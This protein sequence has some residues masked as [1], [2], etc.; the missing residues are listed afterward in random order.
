MEAGEENY[1]LHYHEK[2]KHH[3][4]QYAAGPEALDWDDQPE[5]F[6]WFEGTVK[7]DLPLIADTRHA[8]YTDL[9]ETIHA[10]PHTF[11]L[12]NIACLLELS[13]GLSA[14]KQYGKTKWAL[15][16]NPSSGNLHAEEAYIISN[17][18][19]ELGSGIYH[20]LSRD[21]Q[22]EQRCAFSKNTLPTDSI[23]IGLSSIQW[24]E[25]WKY[26]E[27]AYRYC[28]LDTGH[29]IAALRYAAAILGWQVNILDQTSDQQLATLLGIDRID[30]YGNAEDEHPDVLLTISMNTNPVDIDI[31]E[32]LAAASAGKWYG[33]ANV[34]SQH[35]THQWPIIENIS[36]AAKKPITEPQQK[37]RY[38]FNT[39]LK[40]PCR[41]E[42][43]SL[44][45][46]R[47]SAQTFDGQT[48]I[49]S[50]VF[51]RILDM[52]LPR[53]N[54]APWDCTPWCD[55][56]NLVL[57]VHRV[58]GLQPGLYALVRNPITFASFQADI[59]RE[60][61]EWQNIDGCPPHLPLYN[62]ISSNAQI[63]ATAISCHQDIAGQSCF[64]LAMI[65]DFAKIEKAPWHYRLLY[66][67]AGMI[68]Q[69]LY[70]EAEAAGLQGT[71]IGC[72]FDD[73][74]HE[75]LGITDKRWQS[76]YHFTIGK[77]LHDTRLQTIPPY[78]HLNR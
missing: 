71:G 42:A 76:L 10:K 15:R 31:E 65:A 72:Y 35:H 14:W 23:L 33:Q 77:G 5:A 20:Y 49:S 24:R 73:S 6:R 57:F 29:A 1:V 3:L 34:L 70:L 61:F 21:H 69:V 67:E 4:R 44:I 8:L 22:L 9:Y 2:T 7:T 46:N 32:P 28:Q 41:L 63:L 75:V 43:A 16:C 47:R 55:D 53:S 68:G 74:V 18:V 30:E 19:D 58:E 13:F 37:T 78:A 25:A 27:R 12:D 40:S 59:S 62:L 52:T 17:H 64:S 26:G 48:H 38:Q 54:M 11:T 50:D 60:Q 51:Y 36:G 66:W 56:I 39:P 45:R